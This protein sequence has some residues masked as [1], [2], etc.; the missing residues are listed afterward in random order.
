MQKVA[1]GSEVGLINRESVEIVPDS[2]EKISKNRIVDI[3]WFLV[4]ALFRRIL[5]FPPLTIYGVP[6]F[7]NM[8][9]LSTF[10]F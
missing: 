2:C 1:L 6:V 8:G 7:F 4:R 5:T 9:G 3:I 10:K